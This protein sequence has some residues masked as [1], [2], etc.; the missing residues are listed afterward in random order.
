MINGKDVEGKNQ[1]TEAHHNVAGAQRRAAGHTQQ[2]KADHRKPHTTPDQSGHLLAEEEPQNRDDDHIE[3]GDKTSL[4][5]R[6][7]ADADLLERTGH[8]QQGTANHTALHQITPLLPTLRYANKPQPL[9][10]QNAGD[11]EYAAQ[12]TAHGIEGERAH[13]VHAHRL[14]HEG[15]A[16]DGRRQQQ[17]K[18]ARVSLHSIHS[19]LNFFKLV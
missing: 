12:Q 19:F 7:I 1:R 8:P 9:Q 2:V 18:R 10:Q 4:A 5:D 14:R 13:I 15:R 16:P 6:G 11:Q 3:G 17:H